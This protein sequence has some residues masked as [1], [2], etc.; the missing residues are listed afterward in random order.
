[1]KQNFS[2]LLFKSM[3]ASPLVLTRFCFFCINSVSIECL[4]YAVNWYLNSPV[5][6][7]FKKFGRKKTAILL[8]LLI[9]RSCA[10][11]ARF[12]FLWGQ[13]EIPLS[14]MKIK[15]SDIHFSE[16]LCYKCPETWVIE[17]IWN[18]CDQLSSKRSA[19]RIYLILVYFKLLFR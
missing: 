5:C 13:K 7:F 8:D 3:S 18:F 16:K 15:S 9:Q 4:L 17:W 14:F 6:L 2:S 11:K 1:M 10:Y 12:W 19:Y